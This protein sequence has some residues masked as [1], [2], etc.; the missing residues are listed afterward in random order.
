MTASEFNQAGLDKL[1][2][3]ELEALNRWIRARSLA[4]EEAIALQQAAAQAAPSTPPIDAMPNERFDSRI[5][6]SF[7]GWNG[8]GDRVE[9]ANGMIWEQVGSD[10]LR[11][12]G[13]VESPAVTL[14][15]G[16]F[17]SW[18]MQI[19]GYNKRISVRRV[20]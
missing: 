1:S 17:N 4:E 12:S 3:E 20:Q 2:A 7:G 9:L 15:P 19:E 10:T 18:T 16:L 6:G 14:R 5:V 8:D 13:A 11:L